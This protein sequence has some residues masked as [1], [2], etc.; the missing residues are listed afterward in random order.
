MSIRLGEYWQKIALSMSFPLLTID[1]KLGVTG[2]H[3]RF[4]GT[5]QTPRLWSP[6]RRG[7]A[8]QTFF[9]VRGSI[10]AGYTLANGNI[11]VQGSLFNIGPRRKELPG[12]ELVGMIVVTNAI[13][14]F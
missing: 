11:T 2:T 14:R 3:Y 1:W 8:N 6:F 10:R 4:D 12:G 13:L 5:P 9:P 7:N